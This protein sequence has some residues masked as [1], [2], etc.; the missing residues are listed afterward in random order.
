MDFR[1]QFRN[2]FIVSL[3]FTQRLMLILFTNV[4]F[5]LI[6]FSRGR[7]L[8]SPYHVEFRNERRAPERMSTPRE[9]ANYSV[10]DCD[11]NHVWRR[12]KNSVLTAC[13]FARNATTKR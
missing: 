2:I 1:N 8:V 3:L 11:D 13:F 7:Q 6:H 4:A 9:L 10:V 12:V 5:C